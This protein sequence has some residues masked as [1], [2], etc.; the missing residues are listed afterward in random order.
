MDQGIK[1]KQ[2]VNEQEKKAELSIEKQ[3]GDESKMK[4]FYSKARNPL[5][6]GPPDLRGSDRGL[7]K[8][9]LK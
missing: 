9:D 3:L 6:L 5:T 7:L 1:E 8:Q 4:E 2:E